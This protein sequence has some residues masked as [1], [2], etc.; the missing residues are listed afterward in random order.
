VGGEVEVF[1]AAEA[2]DEIRWD[3]LFGT[4]EVRVDMKEKDFADNVA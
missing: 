4:E 1:R 3:D 2:S